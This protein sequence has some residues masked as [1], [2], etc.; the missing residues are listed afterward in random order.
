MTS[1]ESEI[2]T[3]KVVG[4]CLLGERIG[5]GGMGV[6]YEAKLPNGYPVA[7]KLLRPEL[8]ADSFAVERFRDEATAGQVV[9]HPNVV[10]FIERGETTDGTP[11]L[12]MERVRGEP[13]G[14][15]IEREGPLSPRRAASITGQ[16]LAALDAIH[17]RGIVHG[18]IK[19]DNVLIETRDDGTDVAKLIDFGLAQV[20]LAP[21]AEPMN[22]NVIA[23]TPDYM[24]PEVICGRGSSNVSDLY[25]VG[26]VLYEILTGRTP[27]GG[28]S[29]TQILRR[30]L[31][32]EVTPP[33][34]RS[35]WTI[36]PVFERIVM[37][38]IEKDR[39]LRFPSAS[40]FA[41]ALA[42]A[43]PS[44]DESRSSSPRIGGEA[45]CEATTLS[46]GRGSEPKGTPGQRRLARGTPFRAK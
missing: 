40:A 15:L 35:E 16:I 25:A 4:T 19:S 6:V 42:R 38:A 37:R 44:L 7:V 1:R 31:E 13:L 27:F 11:F 30:H 12:V 34:L 3:G 8:M 21:E 2:G 45:S 17:A 26:V 20:Q 43:M 41:L 28:G 46:W 10:A 29:A 24:A 9:S 18:D 22:G 23:G 36:P 39:R 14:A 32:D 5:V 33:S